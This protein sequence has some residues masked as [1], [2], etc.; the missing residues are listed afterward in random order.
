M[1]GSRWKA[2]Q[3]PTKSLSFYNATSYGST[4]PQVITGTAYTQQD[5]DCLS[6]NIWAPSNGTNLPVSLP[7]HFQC[8]VILISVQVFV[9]NYGGAMVTGSSSNP[10]IVGSNF[11][12]KDVIYVN[13]NHRESL[14]ASPFS[15]ELAGTGESQNFG[16]LDV[17]AALEWVYNNIAGFGGDPDRIVFGGHSS[18][19]VMV[20]HYLWNH[21]DTF[22]AGAIEMSANVM[23]GP[24][25]APENVALD[26]VAAEV[27]CPL[28]NSTSGESQL[29]CLREVDIYTLQTT[30]FNSTTSNWF[31]PT[32]DNIT[33]F[34]DYPSRFS[35]GNYPKSIPLLVG[36]SDQEGEIFAYV[37]S[38]EN[39][40]F[41]SW[42]NTFD[43]DVSHIPDED[44]IAAYNQSDY[45][46]VSLMSGANYGDARFFCTTD[47]LLDIRSSEQDTWIYRWFGQYS[48]LAISGLGPSHGSEVPF[49]HGGNSCFSDFT[50][51]TADWQVLAD[52]MNGWL[53]DFIKE[54]TSGPG[55]DKATAVSGPLTKVGVPGNE[56]TFI[57]SDTADYNGRCQS[58][59]C[60]APQ[61]HFSK[62]IC[63][64]IIH[65]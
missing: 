37:Y 15:S 11:A 38:S 8:M 39:T 59:S 19:S 42:I 63:Y 56:T 2:P 24:V 48:D 5:E 13:F 9:Y 20:D 55:W 45:E 35:A 1:R 60:P 29:D 47:Y 57:A 16:I 30:Y 7:D 61:F 58:V 10:E 49:F 53:I 32:I 21:P 36:N 22:L 41:S 12:S 18:G 33:R 62:E 26:V 43:A 23:S 28:S 51:V 14:W 40:N 64:L 34:S 46:T 27:G 65:A 4:C 44:M 50:N 17:E 3:P 25:Y 52:F 54:P 6:L 31:V